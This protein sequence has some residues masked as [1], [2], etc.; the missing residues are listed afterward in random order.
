MQSDDANDAYDDPLTSEEEAESESA[1]Q[2]YLRGDDPGESL[3]AVREALL[4]RRSA[5]AAAT[6]LRS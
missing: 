6:H 4:V 1:W 3:D 5:R 2:S